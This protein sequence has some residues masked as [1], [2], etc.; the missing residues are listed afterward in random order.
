MKILCIGHSTY[1]ITL[2]IDS[3]LKENTK[4]HANKKVECGGGPAATAAY[5]L[6]KWNMKDT[7][8]MGAVGS[9][10]Y[11]KRVV[12]EFIENN[13]NLDY[14]QSVQ[15]CETPLGLIV[16]SGNGDRTIVNY[17]PKDIKLDMS[18]I[19]F[20]TDIDYILTDGNELEATLK[21]IEHNEKAKIII[22]AGRLSKNSII[23]GQIADYL[24]C[25]QDFAED[26]TNIKIDLSDQKVL[27]NLFKKLESTFTKVIII[28]LGDKGSI[29][30]SNG[31]IEVIPTM[32][33]KSIDTTGAGDI[34]HGAFT[35]AI[36]NNYSV[37]DAM[38]IGSI[39]GAL[40]TETL[41]GMKSIPDLKEVMKYYDKIR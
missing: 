2:Q 37:I 7:Y 3:S 41:G 10:I 13:M 12:E 16:A 34:Y 24:V 30:K 26:Y 1:D 15:G 19:S 18:K 31:K 5:L 8:F 39:A 32:K 11:G 21:L 23:L 27:N 22:D 35:Y 20:P 28:T 38:K 9:D 14:V 17:Y 6:S 40:S 25:S 36:A 4:Y 29:I 33:V